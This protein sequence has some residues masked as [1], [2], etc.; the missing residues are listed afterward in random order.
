MTSGFKHR[1]T[2]GYANRGVFATTN[3]KTA[4]LIKNRY[5][6]KPEP[7]QF[8]CILWGCTFFGRGENL[9]C[10]FHGAPAQPLTRGGA[11]SVKENQKI[12]LN[13]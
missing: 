4:A 5:A 7:T 3:P 13:P 10:P 1:K 12:V 9:H 8:I 6:P 2:V 11:S